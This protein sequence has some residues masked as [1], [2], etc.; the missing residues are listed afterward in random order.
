MCILY[1]FFNL[2]CKICPSDRGY[3]SRS[4]WPSFARSTSND[5]HTSLGQDI[6]TLTLKLWGNVTFPNGWKKAQTY[7]HPII[8]KH[9]LCCRS[10][11]HIER[12]LWGSPHSQ[13]L[14]SKLVGNKATRSFIYCQYCDTWSSFRS[15]KLNNMNYQFQSY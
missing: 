1:H 8:N 2:E 4:F 14:L 7:T 13:L 10:D 15:L 5:L 3:T 9:Q 12:V 11:M 6:Q